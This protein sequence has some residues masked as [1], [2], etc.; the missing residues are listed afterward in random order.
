MEMDLIEWIEMDLSFQP[1]NIRPKFIYIW[2]QQIFR[3]EIADCFH[4]PR[5]HINDIS[6]I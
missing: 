5:E 4:R 3:T 6:F 1:K 2:E